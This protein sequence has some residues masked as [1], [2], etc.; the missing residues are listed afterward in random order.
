MT[1]HARCEEDGALG[2]SHS[3]N[4]VEPGLVTTGEAGGGTLGPQPGSSALQT[5]VLANLVGRAWPMALGLLAVPL[6]LRE[7]ARTNR[8]PLLCH[9]LLQPGKAATTDM[10]PWFSA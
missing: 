3:S 9:G 4:S 8:S 5:A 1:A 10:R 7:L 6:Y 2:V